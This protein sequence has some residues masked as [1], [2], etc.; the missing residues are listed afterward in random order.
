[1]RRH[2]NQD[3][4]DRLLRFLLWH[5]AERFNTYNDVT[6]LR[7]DEQAPMRRLG[8]VAERVGPGSLSLKQV[9]EIVASDFIFQHQVIQLKMMLSGRFT[10]VQ[11]HAR[12]IE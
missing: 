7:T 3:L 2:F 8:T 6:P 10:F 5:C 12:A 9:A 11:P 4:K 1:L